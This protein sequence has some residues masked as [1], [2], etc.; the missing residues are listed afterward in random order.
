MDIKT[1]EFLVLIVELYQVSDGFIY[2]YLFQIFDENGGIITK[3]LYSR[4][5]SDKYLPQE[6]KPKIIPLVKEMTINLVNR[7]K[8]DIIN[9]ISMEKLNDKSI[10]RY[11]EI[12]QLL[13]NELGYKLHFK[14]S[15]PYDPMK[16]YTI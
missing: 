10:I 4:N 1:K 9:R 7:I 16:R 6:I 5:E 2:S 11:N 12:S 3:R 13:E 14:K 8:P 15:V